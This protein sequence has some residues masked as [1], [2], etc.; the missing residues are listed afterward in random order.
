[1]SSTTGASSSR[2]TRG[3]GS[4]RLSVCALPN[5]AVN[6]WVSSWVTADTSS[7]SPARM[8]MCAS[9]CSAFWA[10]PST[11][12]LAVTSRCETMAPPSR[13]SMR[14]RRRR[15]DP[16]PPAVFQS[17]STV[18][19]ASRPES[20]ASSASRTRAIPA[21][22]SGTMAGESGSHGSP[23]FAAVKGLV[24]SRVPVHLSLQS[25]TTPLRSRIA[26]SVNEEDRIA[27]LRASM[28]RRRR[29]SVIRTIT[30]PRRVSTGEGATA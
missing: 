25:S 21:G 20:T 13:R 16:C 1:M 18:R 22:S 2:V 28:L 15:D 17:H 4:M 23:R 11:R 19:S 7:P 9:S 29:Y 27:R 8:F 30:V 26:R 12:L 10:S 14:Q 6:D 5:D 3:S 24:L